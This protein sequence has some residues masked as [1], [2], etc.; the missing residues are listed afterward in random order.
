MSNVSTKQFAKLMADDKVSAI[1][2]A[3]KAADGLTPKQ[4]STKTKIPTNQLYYTLNKMLAADLL[5]IVKQVQVKNLTENYYSSSRLSQEKPAFQKEIA[6]IGGDITGISGEW[7]QAHLPEMLQW[8]MLQHHEFLT[9][10]EHEVQAH[11]DDP[12]VFSSHSDL[13]LSAAG[14]HQ[15]RLDLLKLIANAEKNDPDSENPNK[16]TAHLLI[17]KW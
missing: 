3:T 6:A 17:E 12:A 7:I 9:N 14:E 10:F 11:P 8:T 4:I 1:L 15:L 5:E 13:S 16:R 2:A